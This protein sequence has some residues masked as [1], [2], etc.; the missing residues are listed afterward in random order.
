MKIENMEAY[1]KGAIGELPFAHA[2][3]SWMDT[4]I[5]ALQ[6]GFERPAGEY[7]TSAAVRSYAMGEIDFH[8]VII[9]PH[10]ML[11]GE[12]PVHFLDRVREEQIELKQLRAK[13]A[14]ATKTL[15]RLEDLGRIGSLH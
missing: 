8:N 15:K 10:N 2:P 11:K 5:E 3:S 9:I 6:D 13:M 7:E 4:G 1:I 14:K 12:R